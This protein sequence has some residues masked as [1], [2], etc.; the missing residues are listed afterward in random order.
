MN[1]N[2]DG[3][4][5]NGMSI[6]EIAVVI[7]RDWKRVYFGAAP[8]LSAML[9]LDSISDN[10]GLDSGRSIVTYFLGNATTWRGEIARAVK[11]E[12]NARIK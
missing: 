1:N 11:K 4:K 12:L 5:L 7:Y 9:S 8:Y 6:S 3:R 10:Y 2:F